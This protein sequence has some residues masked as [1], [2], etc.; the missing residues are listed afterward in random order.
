MGVVTL[1]LP[2]DKHERL[3]ELARTRGVSMNK[4]MEDLAT[5]ALAQSDAHIRFLARAGRG[6]PP[7]ALELLDRLDASEQ[8]GSPEDASDQ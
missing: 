4:L 8:S 1:R 6:Q 5:V 7:R 3:R 2:E